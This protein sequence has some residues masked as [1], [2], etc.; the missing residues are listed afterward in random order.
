[1]FVV[2]TGF[3]KWRM[4]RSGHRLLQVIANEFRIFKL[5]RKYWNLLL[6]SCSL[7]TVNL[8]PK[9]SIIVEN[10]DGSVCHVF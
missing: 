1:V 2:P 5:Y 3:D 7:S 8:S 4:I 10:P 6:Q 9:A